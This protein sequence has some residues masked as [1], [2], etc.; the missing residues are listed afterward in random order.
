MAGSRAP[1]SVE[2]H[3]IR[4]GGVMA[5]EMG[6]GT[7]AEVDRFVWTGVN[8][9]GE[10]LVLTGDMV[11]FRLLGARLGERYCFVVTE[12]GPGRVV[13]GLEKMRDET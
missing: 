1:A 13:L 7:T 5:E 6:P 11:A 9:P 12:V 2:W 3:D 4:Q 8:L 10:L